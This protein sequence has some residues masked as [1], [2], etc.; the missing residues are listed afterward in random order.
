LTKQ[1]GIYKTWKKR[2]FSVRGNQILY[3][4]NEEHARLFFAAGVSC[5]SL[6]SYLSFSVSLALADVCLSAHFSWCHHLQAAPLLLT[7][8]SSSSSFYLLVSFACADRLVLRWDG[9]WG[10]IQESKAAL[11]AI[12]LA[13]P[14]DREGVLTREVV[15][16][17]KPGPDDKVEAGR[18]H[19][20]TIKGKQ[21][22]QRSYFLCAPTAKDKEV[23]MDVIT[24]VIYSP[25]GGGM[26]GGGLADQLLKERRGPDAVPKLIEHCVAHLRQNGALEEEG[27]FRLAGRSTEI[28][29]L[30]LKFNMAEW[31]TLTSEDDIHTV[32]SVMKK[33]LRELPTPLLT[34]E[35]SCRFESVLAAASVYKTNQDEGLVILQQLVRDVDFANG[36]LLK[37]L[38]EFLTEVA[39]KSEINKMTTKN[40]A[41]VFAPSFMVP[42]EDAPQQVI[43]SSC[44]DIELVTRIFIERHADVFA[45][46]RPVEDADWEPFRE[47]A[48]AAAAEVEA[49]FED[50]DETMEDGG[51]DAGFNGFNSPQSA[52]T[53]QNSARSAMST[54]AMVEGRPPRPAQP[55]PQEMEEVANYLT[56][57]PA[58]SNEKVAVH[59][60]PLVD[61]VQGAPGSRN[62]IQHLQTTLLRERQLRL[63]LVM[64]LETLKG[65]K[66]A[67]AGGGAAAAGGSSTVAFDP[68]RASFWDGAAPIRAFSDATGEPVIVHRRKDSK[69]IKKR[70]RGEGWTPSAGSTSQSIPI[71]T[72]AAAPNATTRNHNSAPLPAVS[73]SPNN[74]FSPDARISAVEVDFSVGGADYLAVSVSPIEAPAAAAPAPTFTAATASTTA[75]PRVANPF[76]ASTKSKSNTPKPS[77]PNT[78]PMLRSNPAATTATTRITAKT[79]S[80]AGPPVSNK[81]SGGGTMSPGPT[82]E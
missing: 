22:N 53:S 2:W 74:P 60:P 73:G 39:E 47:A 17:P 4:T 52:S 25:K 76:A 19:G 69:M 72:T 49:E 1:G 18:E 70:E 24:R 62:P 20:F 6:M 5:L 78:K 11:G 64:Q 27:M 33:Y 30:R 59:L 50:L 79:A 41:V 80:S 81:R 65:S 57:L 44:A 3:F 26:F 58:P 43:F 34:G 15:S 28:A 35:G 56:D 55:S 66:S 23:W 37:Y 67:A 54:V 63:A 82:F 8:S 16:V 36:I 42:P 75:S 14:L 13:Y 71:P 77:K 31:P 48:A 51:G 9:G 45:L 10:C 12:T 29:A 7:P 32:G 40:L 21:S 46:M 61:A 38:C 68:T